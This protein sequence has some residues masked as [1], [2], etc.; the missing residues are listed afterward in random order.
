MIGSHRLRTLLGKAYFY[1]LPVILVLGLTECRRPFRYMERSGVV[2]RGMGDFR[3]RSR[4]VKL[5]GGRVA[6]R[7]AAP[8]RFTC[9]VLDPAGSAV[10]ILEMRGSRVRWIDLT[11]RC[12]RELSCSRISE[13][14]GVPLSVEWL[15]EALAVRLEPGGKRVRTYAGSDG[16]CVFRIEWRGSD[17]TGGDRIRFEWPQRGVEIGI[18]WKSRSETV[19]SSKPERFDVAG[20][21][22]CRRDW[23]RRIEKLW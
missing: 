11:S 10:G 16:R 15:Y 21:D 6:V 3:F 19:E 20:F 23:L 7:M 12:Y 8:E 14:L 2:F 17:E 1:V 4:N 5:S 13:F 18:S 22:V 9:Q